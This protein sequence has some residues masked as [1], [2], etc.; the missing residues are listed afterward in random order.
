M[1]VCITCLLPVWMSSPFIN[2]RYNNL[3]SVI[4]SSLQALLKAL[5]GLVV[6]SQELE[7]MGNSL[8]DNSVPNMWSKK[9]WYF[10]V[11]TYYH[12]CI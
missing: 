3:L 9:V 4:H 5:K 10:C 11:Y 8:Y 2:Y 1:T 6:L 12:V 7:M